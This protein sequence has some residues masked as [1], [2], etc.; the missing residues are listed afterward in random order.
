MWL[1]LIVFMFFP[2]RAW[3]GDVG[4]IERKEQAQ[5]KPK[6]AALAANKVNDKEFE[7]MRE[8]MRQEE[9]RIKQIKMLNLDLERANLELKKRQVD[10]QLAELG[11]KQGTTALPAADLPKAPIIKLN[12]IVMAQDMQRAWITVDGTQSF[13]KEGQAIGTGLT[14][15]K[16]A[17]DSVVVEHAD[18]N[19]ETIRI[20]I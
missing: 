2:L 4:F 7:R 11:P 15:R 3:A 14:L 9:E 17:P 6:P 10:A 8:F 16:I 13:F 12:G 20:E 18:G 5:E 1:T 19:K